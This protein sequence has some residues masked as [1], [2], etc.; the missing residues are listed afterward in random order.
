MPAALPAP[1]LPPARAGLPAVLPLDPPAGSGIRGADLVALAADAAARCA[2][3]AGG[4]GD[5]GLALD[6]TADLARRGAA[7]LGHPGFAELAAAAG[8][9]A[10]ELARDAIAWRHGG[11]GALA[12]LHTGWQPDPDELAEGRAALDSVDG[13][14]RLAQPAHP[15]AGAAA[16]R[17]GRA[18]VRA[19]PLRHRVGP[20][21]R[22]GCRSGCGAGLR[23]G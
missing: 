2:E 6:G 15:R 10:R 16:A 8:V 20:H 11:A 12:A 21:R 14:T 7:Q 3:L 22:A 19:D 1:P 23:L 17:A 5:G 18:V 13:V 4:T 9:S